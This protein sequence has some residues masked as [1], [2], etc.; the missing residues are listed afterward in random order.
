MHTNKFTVYYQSG[1]GN[2][3][4]IVDK[5]WKAIT[6]IFDTM[7]EKEYSGD[8]DQFHI[9][10]RVDGEY[11]KFNDPEGCNSLKFFKKKRLIAN[12]ISFGE[13]IYCEEYLLSDFLKKNL[14]L[15]FEQMLDRLQRERVV[16]E[17]CQ[18]LSDLT[19]LIDKNFYYRNF[20]GIT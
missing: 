19:G 10:L 2:T 14:L 15:A 9:A 11:L 7:S 8:I 13:K 18:L 5:Y 16:I 20:T 1:G 3:I 12:S 17:R 4:R 6:S